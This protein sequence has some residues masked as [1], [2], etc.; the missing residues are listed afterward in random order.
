MMGFLKIKYET[1]HRDV[2]NSLAFSVQSEPY[3]LQI[4]EKKRRKY[5]IKN[6]KNP[7]VYNL[8]LSV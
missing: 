2:E 5:T 3:L 4:E 7:S 8:F 1:L 6:E